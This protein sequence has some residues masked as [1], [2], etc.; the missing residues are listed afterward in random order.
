VVA[1]RGLGRQCAAPPD[2][3][4]QQELEALEHSTIE[5]QGRLDVLMMFLTVE[6]GGL[7]K[8]G[9]KTIRSKRP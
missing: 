3:L 8:L 6:D 1:R 5:A 9:S 4:D 2:K 7:K